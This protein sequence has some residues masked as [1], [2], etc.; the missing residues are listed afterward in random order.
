MTEI[1]LAADEPF[2]MGRLPVQH[3]RPRGE[4]IQFLRYFRPESIRLFDGAAV[5]LLIRLHAAHMRLGRK[6]RRR[7]EYSGLVQDGA[8]V[9]IFCSLGHAW[10]NPPRG[11]FET[12]LTRSTLKGGGRGR[13]AAQ[14][15]P[16]RMLPETGLAVPQAASSGNLR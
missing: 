6:I 4:P 7:L 9:L 1:E 10:C 16:P 14:Q 3:L 2:G 11:S 12:A 15:S 8:E 13:Q 5:E